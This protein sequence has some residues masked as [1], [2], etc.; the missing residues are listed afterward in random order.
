MSSSLE[1]DHSHP[2]FL[3]A[4]TMRETFGDETRIYILSQSQTSTVKVSNV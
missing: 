4:S 2:S 1:W 3:E